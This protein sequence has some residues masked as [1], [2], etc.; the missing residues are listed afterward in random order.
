[1]SIQSDSINVNVE[2]RARVLRFLE[3]IAQRGEL[4]LG[5]VREAELLAKA[6]AGAHKPVL[7]CKGNPSVADCMMAGYCRRD[8]ACDE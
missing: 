5:E 1:M 3:R 8:P 4:K 7:F 2:I 6:F